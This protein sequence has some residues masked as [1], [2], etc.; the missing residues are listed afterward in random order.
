[1]LSCATLQV[2]H[3]SHWPSRF[4]CVLSAYLRRSDRRRRRRLCQRRISCWIPARGRVAHD[5]RGDRG[6]E[7]PLASQLPATAN[8]C[9]SDVL[10]ADG[11]LQTWKRL[12]KC[13]SDR[14]C[15]LL[16]PLP[17]GALSRGLHRDSPIAAPVRSLYFAA[18]TL[19]VA[20]RLG[21]V[22]T[23]VQGPGDT[24]PCSWQESSARF[25]SLHCDMLL[26]MLF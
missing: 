24:V 7:A 14:S 23:W 5:P 26:V 16:G 11:T 8:P 19:L 21:F 10:T 1:M 25:A 4:L 18:A 17:Q 20:C 13:R 22:S 12:M 9:H 15:R 3:L 2:S 6:F